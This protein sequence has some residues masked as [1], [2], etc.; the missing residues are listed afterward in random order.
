MAPLGLWDPIVPASHLATKIS[1]NIVS[2]E[3]TAPPIKE[4]PMENRQK[5]GGNLDVGTRHFY[6]KSLKKSAQKLRRLILLHFGLVTFRYPF[7]KAENRS[8][9]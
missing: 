6:W 4:I 7:K 1:R 2:E 5:S 9:S 3:I 8:F